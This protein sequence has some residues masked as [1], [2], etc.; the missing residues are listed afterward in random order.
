[1]DRYKKVMKNIDTMKEEFIEIMLEPIHHSQHI[2]VAV[3][4]S[5]CNEFVQ[6]NDSLAMQSN[7]VLSPIKVKCKGR[8][9]STRMVPTVEKEVKKSQQKKKAASDNNAKPKSGKKIG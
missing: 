7:I 8:S 3:V 9:K 6:S 1:V 2:S 4:S 5:T